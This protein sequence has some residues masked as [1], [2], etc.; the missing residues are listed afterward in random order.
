MKKIAKALL[1]LTFCFGVLL[2]GKEQVQ[3]AETDSGSC[4]DS[5]TWSY[6]GDTKKLTLYGEGAVEYNGWSEYEYQIETVRITKNITDLSGSVFKDL[7]F[8]K[9]FVVDG[10]NS[11]Y[12]A[13]DGV[14]LE[15]EIS[16][17]IKYPPEKSEKS[18]NIPSRVTEIDEYAF[19]W[20]WNL[21]EIRI[22][23][24]V[25]R[26]GQGAFAYCKYLKKI[27]IPDGVNF[28]WSG[29]FEGCTFL[30][31]VVV[32]K[33]IWY[34]ATDV[35]EG[36][37]STMKVYTYSNTDMEEY[38]LE[39]GMSKQL[40]L[41]DKGITCTLNANGGSC[42]TKSKKVYPAYTYKTLP[43]PTRS[44]YTFQGWYTAKSG[45]RKITK[46]SMVEAVK[47]HT[48]YA[49]WKLNLPATA[50]IKV[51]TKSANA[52]TVSWKKVSGAKGYQIYRATSANGSYK[53]CKIISTGST[54]SYV[55]SKLTAGK[56]YYY[57]VRAYKGTGS[58]KVYGK[59]SQAVK[60]KVYGALKTPKLKIKMNKEKKTFTLSWNTVKNAQKIEVY[61]RIDD[62]AWK[63][64]AVL[65]V[66]KGKTVSYSYEKMS[67][68]HEYRYRIR[69]Y[70]EVDGKKIYSEYSNVPGFRY[71]M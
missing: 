12:T 4:G 46:S 58:K 3:A 52:V 45:G 1:L 19:T 16:K 53:I 32:P 57:R 69:A 43:T 10:A 61:Q 59:F 25:N 42:S 31:C 17:I 56:T 40:V 7:M 8:L 24:G 60:K 71:G 62:N 35:F 50:T 54:T 28:L 48:L 63:K 51:K 29:V 21:E 14:L 66:S 30:K 38:M 65:A 2:A 37:P 64:K 23:S 5:T 6:D 55:D 44:G 49:H 39:E 47:A 68:G 13:R 67:K 22:P 34:V 41:V 20:C 33:S 15:K 11:Y 26:I 9:K 27:V 70:Y 36:C 18:Y